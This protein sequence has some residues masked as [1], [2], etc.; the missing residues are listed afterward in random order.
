MI[1]APGRLLALIGNVRLGL[2]CRT[3]RN[4]LA[5]YSVRVAAIIVV[6]TMVK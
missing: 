2:K 4:P 6:K 1:Q 5:Y 3:V